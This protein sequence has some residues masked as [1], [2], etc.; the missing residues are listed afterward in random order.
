MRVEDHL[1][2]LTGARSARRVERIQSLWSG[3]GEIV[4]YALEG[5]SSPSVVVKIVRPGRGSERGSARKH[6]SYE[7]EAAWYRDWSAR[8][9]GVCRVPR[10][11][12]VSEGL[13]VLEDLD[14]AGYPDRWVRGHRDDGR[15]R[16]CVEWLA[17]FHA[18]FLGSEPAG[19]WPEG[20]YWHLAT[21]PDEHR[22]MVP[23]PLKDAASAIATTLATARI[24]TLVHGDAKVANFCFG[25][26]GVAAVDFQYVGGGVGVKDLVYFLGSALAG[27]ELVR[28]APAWI[29]RYFAALVASHP[30]GPEA[31]AEWR[32][33]LPFAWADF[34]RFLAGWSPGHRDRSG[35]AAEQ[36]ALAVAAVRAGSATPLR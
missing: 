7:V 2:A 33:L 29:D 6:R 27:P 20:T 21:R 5:A 14:A 11:L 32:R 36:T 24:Q 25:A 9:E 28:S 30:R 1:C 3:W 4:R 31:E 12:H 19:L 13:F 17:A 35:Y 16:V 34:E 22:A 26:G 23:G 15:V 8:C 10:A 18:H